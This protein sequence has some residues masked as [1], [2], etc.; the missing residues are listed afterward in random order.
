MM[1][2]IFLFAGVAAA[3]FAGCIPV[4][5]GRISGADLARSNATL[6]AI[7]PDVD[8]GYT[9]LA[10]AKRV[11]RAADLLRIAKRFGLDQNGFEEVCFE[12]PQKPLTKQ[13]V[14]GAIQRALIGRYEDECADAAKTGTAPANDGREKASLPK[15]VNIDLLEFSDRPV[16]EGEIRFSAG[17]LA[18]GGKSLN[19]GTLI[20]GIVRYGERHSVPIWARIR[21]TTLLTAVFTR[22]AIAVGEAVEPADVELRRVQENPFNQSTPLRLEEVTGKIARRS[23]KAGERISRQTLVAPPAVRGGEMVEVE[24]RAGTTRLRLRAKAVNSASLGE[25]VVLINPFNGKRFTARVTQEGTAVTG[26]G[27]S[28]ND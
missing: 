14:L 7:P 23:Y 6:R 12:I 16:P 26:E 15:K 25:K 28:E 4:P 24:A 9:P 13:Q 18:L 21:A 10:G 17:A 11:F 19:R 3:A 27:S 22:R 8:F 2:R 1:L 5:P 20:R